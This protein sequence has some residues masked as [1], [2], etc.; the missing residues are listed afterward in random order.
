MSI[1][2]PSRPSEI[3]VRLRT[4]CG[5]WPCYPDGVGILIGDFILC[6]PEEGLFHVAT[7]TFSDGDPGSTAVLGSVFPDALEVAQPN[8][9]RKEASADGTLRILSRIDRAFVNIPVSEARDFRCGA[10]TV[11]DFGTSVCDPRVGSRNLLFLF[12][13]LKGDVGNAISCGRSDL[14]R[15]TPTSH[16]ARL[17]CGGDRHEGI[18]QQTSR[19]V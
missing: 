7:Q 4:I 2:N 17:P 10:Q 8:Y 5:H 11:D 1:W 19:C 16:G 6:E 14:V 13:F 12:P 9:T 18:P 15:A 3:R